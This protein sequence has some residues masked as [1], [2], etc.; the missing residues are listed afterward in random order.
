MTEDNVEHNFFSLFF[1]FN[2]LSCTKFPSPT[3]LKMLWNLFR[4]SSISAYMKDLTLVTT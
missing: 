4:K 2:R 3:L 1:A